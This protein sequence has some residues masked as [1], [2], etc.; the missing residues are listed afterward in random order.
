MDCCPTTCTYPNI[1]KA[2][3]NQNL[4]IQ[5]YSPVS[6]HIFTITESIFL[7]KIVLI[8]LI[9]RILT[10]F[11]IYL[12]LRTVGSFQYVLQRTQDIVFSIDVPQIILV[13]LS[14]IVFHFVL[15]ERFDMWSFSCVML[16]L[17]S[18]SFDYSYLCG[19]T[20]NITAYSVIFT[21]SL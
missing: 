2:T 20:E 10:C 18:V 15:Q 12:L 13:D 4:R 5:A 16:F 8:F 21:I 6:G 14:L 3:G 19:C 7:N 17:L 11:E 9:G 1:V